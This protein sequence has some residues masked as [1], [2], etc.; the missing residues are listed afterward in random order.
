MYKNAVIPIKYVDGK[1]SEEITTNQWVT[2][3]C[4]LHQRS[5]ISTLTK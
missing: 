3:G 2:Q 1:M 4:G 5:S